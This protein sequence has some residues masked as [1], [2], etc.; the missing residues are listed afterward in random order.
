MALNEYRYI[1]LH[2]KIKELK[3]Y[4]FKILHGIT[5]TDQQLEDLVN[6]EREKLFLHNQLGNHKFRGETAQEQRDRFND[7][8]ITY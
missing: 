4:E 3:S 1:E 6:I 8:R 2:K 7:N 5:P